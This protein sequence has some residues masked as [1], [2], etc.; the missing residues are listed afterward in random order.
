M[1]G[2]AVANIFVGCFQPRF[3]Q[4]NLRNGICHAFE[5]ALTM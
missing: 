5:S 4:Q 3:S 1:D 2:F